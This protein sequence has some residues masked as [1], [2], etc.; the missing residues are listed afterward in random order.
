MDWS[1]LGAAIAITFMILAGIIGFVYLLAKYEGTV[2]VT[3][4]IF[5]FA[6]AVYFV[7]LILKAGE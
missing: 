2:L 5:V 3:I 6:T 4:F 7:Y 1:L